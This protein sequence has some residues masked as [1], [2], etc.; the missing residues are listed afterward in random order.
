MQLLLYI[1]VYRIRSYKRATLN[2]AP[3]VVIH[4]S[5]KGA[6][7][8]KY[9][10]VIIFNGAFIRADMLYIEKEIFA[11]RRTNLANGSQRKRR[12]QNKLHPS[13]VENVG[14][15]YCAKS[16]HA[17]VYSISSDRSLQDGIHNLFSD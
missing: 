3:I 6:T 15:Y 7:H 5:P 14:F 8:D 2:K 16:A 11:A 13:F 12:R 1:H 10:L 4:F 9:I 17:L